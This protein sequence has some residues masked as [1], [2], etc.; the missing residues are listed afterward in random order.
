[1]SIS[2]DK[3]FI[4]TRNR[5]LF[6]NSFF[7]K[8]LVL[9][10]R[11]RLGVPPQGF[12]NIREILGWERQKG[13]EIMKHHFPK[14]IHWGKESDTRILEKR[15]VAVSKTD[16]ELYSPISLCIDRFKHL[17]L[18]FDFIK[19]IVLG[20]KDFAL[21]GSG[22]VY[23][24]ASPEDSLDQ[25][26]VYIKFSPKFSNKQLL[27][28]KKEASEAYVLFQ[29]ITQPKKFKLLKHKKL[30]SGS[31]EQHL[32]LYEAVEKQYLEQYNQHPSYC[33][34]GVIFQE[35]SKK[36]QVLESTLRNTYYKI[37]ERY[38]LPSVTE[39]SKIFDL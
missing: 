11:N 28:L 37:Q 2:R 18:R 36:L 5:L 39:A 23:I 14:K 27:E 17:N 19:A 38:N 21:S 10:L 8:Q 4:E 9:F 32:K 15:L 30:T 26:G 20:H 1:M 24:V 3:S 6:F 34:L 22:M 31:L 7:G 12:A 29:K 25:E 33:S 35:L 13:T 16:T